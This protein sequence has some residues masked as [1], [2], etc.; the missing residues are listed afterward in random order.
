MM[1]PRCEGF[2]LTELGL[3]FC[4]EKKINLEQREKKRKKIWGILKQQTLL[5]SSLLHFFFTVILFLNYI[6][7]KNCLKRQFFA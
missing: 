2:S 4:S 7:W 1:L 3:V 6:I 5:S